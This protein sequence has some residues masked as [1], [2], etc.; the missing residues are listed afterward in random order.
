MKKNNIRV[1]LSP[2]AGVT[3]RAF[4]CICND[5]NVDYAYT[6]MVSAKGLFYSD[7]TTRELLARFPGEEKIGVQLF[8]SDPEIM[9]AMAKKISKEYR[10]F[11]SIDINMGCPAKK[12]VKNKEGSALMKDPELVRR[13]I[14][15][16][17]EESNLP[18]SA[19]FRL[20][21]DDSR[22]NYLEIGR[23]CQEAGAYKVTLHART[24]EQMYSG[25]ADWDAIKDLREMLDIE[26]VGN[27][28]IFTPE[29]ALRMIEYTGV[30]SVAIGRGAMGNPFIFKQIKDYFDK[31]TYDLP[32][33]S[34]II[35]L[36]L[37]QYDLLVKYKGERVAIN[38][39]RKHIAWYLKGYRGAN[40][41]KNRINM[42]RSIDEVF[43]LL[44]DFE[45]EY[46]S[47]G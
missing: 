6:E 7:K 20:G 21:Y 3:D 31:G 15:S 24:R 10:Y 28:D 17:R 5:Y 19:K 40:Q 9:G 32:T 37:R 34:D 36:I 22:K 1:I 26:V 46:D 47:N 2:L 4:R 23:I 45:R 16:V 25:K 12:I 30:N 8:G 29:D 14:S 27:G 44:N 18:V 35:S 39:M 13:I 11:K 33:V 42:T 41:L 38:E 43:S